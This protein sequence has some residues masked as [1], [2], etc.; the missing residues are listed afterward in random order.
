MSEEH[1][2]LDDRPAEGRYPPPPPRGVGEQLRAARERLGL[3]LD[4]VARETRVSVRY[5]ENIEAG[6]FE[7]LPG[8]TYAIG[9]AKSYA[10]L[11]GLD[12]SDVAEMVG[13][14]VRTRV[15][16]PAPRAP[17]FEPGDPARVPSRRLG[18]FAVI[19]LVLLLVGLFFA[20]R[21][22]FA[23]AAELPS[24]VAQ[25][26]QAERL[27]AARAAAERAERTPAARSP[28]GPVVFTATQ[29][30]IWVK[31]YDADGAQLMQKIMAEGESYT[32]P[33]DARGP[34]LWTGRP[35]ALTITVGGRAV[36]P[37][38]EEDRIMRD[39]PVTAEALLRRAEAGEA[40]S[41]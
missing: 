8:R 33:A 9:F 20:A 26:E 29:D 12:Q 15:P 41:G 39:V 37:L 22:M 3:S 28:A 38:A 35:D 13:A 25:Q 19:A 34:Q 5:L 27:A 30:D 17:A 2:E 18:L 1:W 16:R 31:F 6:N 24:L 11:V 10:K 21:L 14:E 32:V 7:A 23:P 40:P 4:D 36:P